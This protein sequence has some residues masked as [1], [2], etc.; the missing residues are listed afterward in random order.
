[1]KIKFDLQMFAEVVQG[2]RIVY[3]YRLNSEEATVNG[4]N[5]AFVTENSRSLSVD[6]DSTETKDGTIVTPGALEHEH[7]VT[8]L[9]KKGDTMIAKLE[10]ACANRSLMDIW[11][12]N[13][14]EAG[15][16]SGTFKGKYFQGYITEFEITS[17]AEDATEISM[18]F[19]LSG[20]GAEGDVTVTNN[21]QAVAAYAFRDTPKTGG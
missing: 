14:E 13:L 3:L 15:A 10:K 11:E 1:M 6:S 4:T 5:I 21:Q 19:A 18:T 12:A 17:N 8:S 7:E 2:K 16:K 20:A 9:L